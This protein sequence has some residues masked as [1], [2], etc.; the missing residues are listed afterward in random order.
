[1]APAHR[2]RQPKGLAQHSPGQRPGNEPPTPPKALKGRHKRR[3]RLRNGL[4]G[5]AAAVALSVILFVALWV[6]FPFP[7][8]QLD[9]P[10]GGVQVLDR[11][12]G[13]LRPFID[14]DDCWAFETEL[15]DVSPRLVEA[16]IAVEDQ[17]F[18]THPGVDPLA[19]LRAL[20]QIVRHRRIVS[21]ASTITMQA[22]RLLEPRPRTILTKAIEAFRALQLERLRDKDA[23]LTLYL[24]RAPY[25]GNLV[26]VEAASLAYFGKHARDLT[27]AEAA[28]LAGLPQSPSRLRPDRH[29]ERARVR[30]DHVLERMHACGFITEG[31]LALARRQP[32]R[33]EREPFP[34]DA[35][36]LARLVRGRYPGRALLQT[37]LDRRVQ[38]LAEETIR[39]AVAALRR[40]GVTNGAVVVIENKTAAVRAMVGSCDFRADADDGQVNGAVA[41]RS[42]GSALKPFTYA[43]AFERGIATPDTILA[44]VPASYAGYDPENYDHTFRGPVTAREALSDSLNVPAVRLLGQVGHRPL[45]GLLR[46]LGLST[47]TRDADHYGL[48]LTLGSTEV[49]LLELTNAYAAL[50]RLGVYKPYRLLETEPVA[51]GQRVLSDG[52]AWLVAD[53]LSDAE[54]LCRRHLPGGE[55]GLRMA[56]KTG[57]SFGH[58]D[59]WTVA[60]TPDYTVGVWVGNFDGRPSAAL[61]GVRAAAPVAVRLMERL[62]GEGRPAWFHRPASVGRRRICSISGMP[63]GPHCT[64]VA[65]GFYLP[66]RSAAERCTVHAEVRIDRATGAS[67]C[68]LCARGRESELRLV[69]CWPQELAAWLRQHGRGDRLA[70][71]HWHGCRRSATDGVP[72]SILSPADGQ[73]YVLLEAAHAPDERLMLKAASASRSLYW[74]VDGALVATGAPLVPTF[75]PLRRGS[76]T[77]VCADGAGR[78]SRLTINVR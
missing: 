59:A 34:F 57:T 51:D 44:D 37:T 58:R 39:E 18:R 47:L 54:K 55:G 7:E 76:H 26:G 10:G 69:E 3:R 53:V 4:L 70:P 13:V 48:S 71:P 14:G 66:G 62:Y 29:P 50:A 74:F 15:A 41:P 5:L 61:V 52:A 40:D 1:M 64:A 31:E 67:L 42:P 25:G 23:I 33:V 38:A 72:P 77:I 56:W 68:P 65:E 8:H 12:G 45:H 49:T 21:G 35:P 46:R 20:S 30:R 78:S 73:T 36:H 11:D 9:S 22:I 6:A 43:L 27:L 32:V 75:W 19:T 63:P 17:R 60:Y 16:T 24:N 2:G 28:L